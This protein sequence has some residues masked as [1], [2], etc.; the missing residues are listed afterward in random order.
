MNVSPIEQ[1]IHVYFISLA[2]ALPADTGIGIH[3][4]ELPDMMSASEGEVG[5]G[6]ADIGRE[7]L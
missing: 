5:H 4:G 3:T 2:A 6:K 1:A 7:V